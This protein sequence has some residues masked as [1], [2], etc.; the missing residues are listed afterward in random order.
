[1]LTDKNGNEIK[2]NENKSV[3]HNKAHKIIERLNVV[4]ELL[5]EGLSNK[6]IISFCKSEY[7]IGQRAA[8]YLLAA[9]KNQLLLNT[10]YDINTISLSN[11]MM[12]LHR[13][14]MQTKNYNLAFKTI[15]SLLRLKND[16]TELNNALKTLKKITIK[17]DDS[18]EAETQSGLV[19][20]ID[21]LQKQHDVLYSDFAEEAQIIDD[22][23]KSNSDLNVDDIDL[24]DLENNPDFDDEDDD[25]NN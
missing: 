1:M 23:N 11:R 10:Q 21:N 20:N 6:D 3:R 17:F 19:T 13:I 9:A 4:M 14:A 16:E 15:D 12:Y 5:L 22:Y 18:N 25:V 2:I 8:H 7:A 24:N